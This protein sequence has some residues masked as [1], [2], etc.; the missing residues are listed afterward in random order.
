V[1]A[2]E[3]FSIDT[4]PMAHP[5][6]RTVPTGGV[7]NPMPKLRIKMIPKCTGSTPRAG[8]TGERNGVKIRISGA[9]SS[10]A[11]NNHNKK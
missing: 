8:T 6:K 11:T 9:I 1:S 3:P 2:L 4:L 10:G 7:I 5:T